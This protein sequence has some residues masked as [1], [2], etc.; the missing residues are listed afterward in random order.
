MPFTIL[1]PVLI[2]GP[3]VKGN[4]ASLLR[5]ARSPW[6]LPFGSLR[7]RRSLL[8]R[9]NLIAA[10]HF[11]L[12][13]AATAGE[14]YV[15]AD[16]A[17]LTLGEL[18][19]AMRAGL[20]RGPG[21]VPFPPSLMATALR[22]ADRD[23]IWQRIGGGLVADPGKLLRAGWTPPVETRAGLAAMAQTP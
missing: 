8:A 7:N 23:E 20:G 1:R 17:P 2:Y 19:G 15:A 12:N 11:A 10:I 4:L 22:L 13:E 14:T 21:I 9:Q 3:G 16:P 5:L 18:V 6:P